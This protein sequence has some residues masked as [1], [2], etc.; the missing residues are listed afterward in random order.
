MLANARRDI[1]AFDQLVSV[2][3]NTPTLDG[4][5][6]PIDAF[7][8]DRTVWAREVPQRGG[9][10]FISQQVIG[11]GVLVLELRE[12]LS[13]LTVLN[14]IRFRSKDWDIRDIRIVGRNEG[15]E[16]DVTVRSEP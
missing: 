15:M 9:E 16:L 12:Y 4:A 14:R 8:V 1:G 3:V 2:L 13:G 7:A 10:R 6:Q 11:T 5:G